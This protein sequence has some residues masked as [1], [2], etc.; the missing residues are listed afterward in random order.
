MSLTNLGNFENKTQHN[1]A[2][3]ELFKLA[4]NTFNSL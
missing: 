2:S 3:I 4:S 1:L